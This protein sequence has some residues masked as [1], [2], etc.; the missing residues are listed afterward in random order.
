MDV[1]TAALDKCANTDNG[2][3]I[4]ACQPLVASVDPQYSYNCPPEPPLIDEP[5]RGIISKLPGC[6][7]IT[8]GPGRASSSDMNCP[9]NVTEPSINPSQ[10]S[11]GPKT[12]F[13]PTIGAVVSGWKYLGC[14]SE[15]ANGRSLSGAAY[16]DST[17][18]SNSA[19]Q[20]F[21]ASKKFPLAATEY[22]SECYC[23]LSLD[24]ASSLNQSCNPM[25]CSG[26]SSEYCGGP[27]RLN[28][29]N[30]TTYSAPFPS[31]VGVSLGS[32]T[33]LGCA[34]ETSSRALSAAGFTNSTGMTNSAC[35]AF[36]VS[37]NYALWGTEFGQEYVFHLYTCTSK[38]D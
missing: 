6:I 28:V 32:S 29:W 22:G 11:S 35:Q 36:C 34:N 38:N 8:S 14:A 1:Q 13:V 24:P 10:V 25:I 3:Q 15:I 7:T 27:S 37:K 26:N 5:T 30:S 2:G 17:N 21:C 12:K 9:A 18:M 31:A 23:G 20:A 19:C 4:S 33:Y 16:T